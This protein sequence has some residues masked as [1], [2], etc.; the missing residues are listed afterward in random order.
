MDIRDGIA[1][2]EL[3]TAALSIKKTQS[4]QESDISKK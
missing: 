2:S 4:R 1:V 3:D